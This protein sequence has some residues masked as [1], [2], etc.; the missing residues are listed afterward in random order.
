MKALL[1]ADWDTLRMSEEPIP[2]PGPG[3]VRLKVQAAGICGSELEAVK[4]HSPRRTPPLIL[5]HE[6]TGVVEALG[7]GVEGWSVGD[8]VVANAVIADGTCPACRRGQTHLCANRKLFGMH[9]PGAFA[10]FVTVPVAT[11]IPRPPGLEPAKAAMSEPLGNGVHVAG[12]L[13]PANPRNVVVYGAGPIGLVVVQALRVALGARVA[14]VEP[15]VDRAAV[16][17]SVGAEATFAPN[18]TTAL[19][20]WGG[21]DGIEAA[22]DAVGSAA[23]KTAS[24]AAVRSGGTVVWIGLHGNEAPLNS[25]DLILTEKQVL[26]SYAC[27]QSQLATALDWIARGKVDVSSW[28]TRLP[29]AEADVAFARMLRP[30]P[31]DIK[32]VLEME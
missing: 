10:E 4:N 24:I 15:S 23:T 12:L 16:A 20:A 5:G 30:G 31:G 2:E 25:Y 19:A 27:T 6:F 3:E 28:V 11:L 26:G 7:R 9:R 32:A 14:V 21:E 13:A 22:V 18:E 8:P 1:Y 29:L 17:V